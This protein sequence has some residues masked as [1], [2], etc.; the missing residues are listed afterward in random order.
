MFR[1]DDPQTNRIFGRQQTLTSYLEYRRAEQARRDAAI[2]RVK[3]QKKSRRN[4]AYI[5]AAINIGM[6]AAMQ[7]AANTNA[8]LDAATE[9]DY[10]TMPV[11]NPGQ[12]A[13]MNRV[14]IAAR[15][16]SPALVMGLSLIHI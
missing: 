4:K 11:G 7:H 8:K 3:D 16:G 5:S 2:Q 13:Q 15:G 10:N 6:G 1:D 14:N 9:V 12:A